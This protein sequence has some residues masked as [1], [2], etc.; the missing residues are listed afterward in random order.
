MKNSNSVKLPRTLTLIPLLMV[1]LT[2]PACGQQILQS[3]QT[4]SANV[5][6]PSGQAII[7]LFDGWFTNDDGTHSLCFGYFNLNSEQS[8]DIPLGE[9][10]HLSDDRFEALV[11]T[12]FDPLPPR[13]RHKF[14]VFT[15]VVPADYGVDE[16]VIWT[17]SSAGQT[18]SVPGRINPPYVID[19]PVSGGR[20][21]IAPWVRTS[22]DGPRVRGRNGIQAENVIRTSVGEE[23]TIPVWIE[24]PEEDV[25]LGWAKHSGPGD[26]SFSM[27]EY[28]LAMDNTIPATRST[29]AAVF[30]EPGD[31]VVRM[32]TINT[33]AAFEF[34]CCHTNAYFN[35]SVTP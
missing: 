17:I 33:I 35:I 2:V 9:D 20:G 30:S 28:E 4:W 31:Y 3:Q 16:E 32:Q 12:H 7:P 6:T 24:H 15:V 22:I 21:N 19:E 14:C 10:N 5:I 1:V 34:Y 27:A 13:Y 26:V 18:L 23:V 25:W 11:P 29:A 8:L